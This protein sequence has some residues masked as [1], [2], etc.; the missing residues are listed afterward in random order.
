[1]TGGYNTKHKV[2]MEQAAK[3]IIGEFTASQLTLLVEQIKTTT[4]KKRRQVPSE[5]EVIM[6]LRTAT[7]AKPVGMKD[8]PDTNNTPR[9]HTAYVYDP[10]WGEQR[11][12]LRLEAVSA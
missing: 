8:A 9:G 12:A 10:T 2:L 5:Q 11:K 6:L 3:T 7:W 4:G 1:M